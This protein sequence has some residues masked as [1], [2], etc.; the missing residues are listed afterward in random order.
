MEYWGLAS[1]GP[2]RNYQGL[3]R[4]CTADTGLLVDGRSKINSFL[5]YVEFNLRAF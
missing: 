5:F 4:L 2:T 3:H 1:R